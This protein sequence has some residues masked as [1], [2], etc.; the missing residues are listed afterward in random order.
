V[1][2]YPKI[3]TPTLA[4]III[5]TSLAPSP[6]A[7]VILS[8][9]L[10]KRT[11]SAF[12]PGVT[13]QKTTDLACVMASCKLVLCYANESDDPSMTGLVS[14]GCR[15]FMSL[16]ISLRYSSRSLPSLISLPCSMS[17]HDRAMF[18]AVYSLSPVSMINLIPPERR[19]YIVSATKSCSLS[20]MPVAPNRK[21]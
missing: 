16:S 14:T 12:W 15:V 18:Y 7:N 13:L 9:F 17:L 8:I 1:P 10:T 20:S 6:I 2:S 19:E 21:S 5:F 11:I 3:P 4:Y